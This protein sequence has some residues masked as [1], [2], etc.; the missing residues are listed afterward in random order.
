V[1]FE[2]DF[3]NRWREWE[4]YLFAGWRFG[5]PVIFNL[6]WRKPYRFAENKFSSFFATNTGLLRWGAFQIVAVVTRN[7]IPGRGI[8]FHDTQHAI[9]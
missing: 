9:I 1:G 2:L 3:G 7:D 5:F 4:F 8:P 6:V